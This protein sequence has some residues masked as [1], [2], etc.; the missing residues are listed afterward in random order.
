MVAVFVAADP[1]STDE[2]LDAVQFIIMGG[3]ALPTL[4]LPQLLMNRLLA[5]EKAR[6]LQSLRSELQEAA[7]PPHERDAFEVLQR[8]QRHQHLLH[9]I[10]EAK[11]F[12]PSLVDTRFALQIGTSMTGIVLANVVLRTVISRFLQ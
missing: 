4:V 11:A 7:T 10:Q 12:V 3:I 8:M 6:E 2:P 5:G 9:E 1:T